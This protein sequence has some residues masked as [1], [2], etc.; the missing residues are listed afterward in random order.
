MNVCFQKSTLYFL[1][2]TELLRANHEMPLNLENLLLPTK[3]R[4]RELPN[5]KSMVSYLSS[6]L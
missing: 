5:I 3:V 1:R 4:V 2:Q 6:P